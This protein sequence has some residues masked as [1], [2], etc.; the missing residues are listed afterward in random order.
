[1]SKQAGLGDNFLIS[2]YDLSGDVAS[3]DQI[4]GGPDLIDVTAINKSAHE[5]I[6]GLRSGDMQFT[7]FF[8]SGGSATAP[9]FPSS[10]TA[11]ATGYAFPVIVTITGGTISD[12]SVNGSSVGTSD[13]SYVVPSL[14][15]ITVTYTGTPSW[16]WTAQGTE[17]TALSSLPRTDVIATYLRGTTLGNP[18]AC[19]N[20]KQVNYDP[21]RD[22]S[23]NLTLKVQVQANGYGLEWG[24]QV[25]A[26]LRTDTAAT[27]GTAYD[28]GSSG[29]NGCQAYLQL[30]EF[31]G[32]SV[33]VK[34]THSSTSGGTYSTLLDFGSL[35]AVGAVR[36]TATGTVNEFLKV[37]TTGTFTLAT[38][39]VVLVKNAIATV[40]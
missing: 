16:T 35:S 3:L 8:N 27:T 5:R 13:G 9:S 34:I 19:I 29:A 40:F 28:L 7:S 1:M 30:V 21:T 4:S 18:A 36:Q 39:N 22:T 10:G 31:A 23:G 33:D 24:T 11:Q 38:F 32:T 37:V 15:T 20:G 2:G 17:H 12:V 14:G 25:T 6:G 26:G